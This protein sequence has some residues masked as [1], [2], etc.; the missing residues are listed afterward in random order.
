MRRS[1]GFSL[2]EVLLVVALIA[3]AGTLAVA[4]ARGGLDGMR[5]RSSARTLAAELRFTRAQAIASGRVQRFEID[6]ARHR[7]QAAGKHHGEIPKALGVDFIGAREVQPDA[8]VGAI[9][10]WPDGGSSG[11]RVRLSRGSAA[12]DVDVAWLTGRVSVAPAERAR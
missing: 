12:W 1:A 7:W 6:P 4:V 2:L 5:L 8:G 9:Q 11:G 10:F 3:L